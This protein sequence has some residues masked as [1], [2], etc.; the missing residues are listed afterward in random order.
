MCLNYGLCFAL[1]WMF[2]G[3]SGDL[4]PLF[5]AVGILGDLG[6]IIFIRRSILFCLPLSKQIFCMLDVPLFAKNIGVRMG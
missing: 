4:G 6:L 3:F 1:Q 5:V 2:H